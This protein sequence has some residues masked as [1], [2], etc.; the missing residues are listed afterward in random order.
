MEEMAIG[1]GVFWYPTQRLNALAE[2]KSVGAMTAYLTDVMFDKDTLMISN[3]AGGGNLG[4]KQLCP[5]TVQ[6]IT[7]MHYVSYLFLAFSL[8]HEKKQ[9]LYFL[10]TQ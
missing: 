5:R 3:L 2:G 6:A 9:L 1:S 8:I 10:A 4:Y 7:G